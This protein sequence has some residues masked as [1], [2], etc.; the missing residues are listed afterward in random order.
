MNELPFFLKPDAVARRYVGVRVIKTMFDMDI[1][2]V[3]FEEIKVTRQFVEEKYYAHI[4][5][6]PYF[7]WS[8]DFLIWKEWP[9]GWL[10]IADCNT[11]E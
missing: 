2:I 8:V 1:K 4:R 11:S 3:H 10:T 6:K 9:K 5:D 7:R